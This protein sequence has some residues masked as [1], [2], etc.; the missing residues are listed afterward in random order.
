MSYTYLLEQGEEF[1]AASF[2]D[3]PQSVLSRLNLIAGK[4]CCKG[5]GTESCQSSQSGMMSPP[6]TE[7]L[8][9]G[10]LMSSAG[11]FLVKTSQSLE[12]GAGIEGERSGLWSEMARIIGEIRPKF[13]FMENSPMLAL[14]GLGRVLG[15]LSQLG[16]YARWGVLG[17]SHIGARHRRERLWIVG[18]SFGKDVEVSEVVEPFQAHGQFGR[19]ASYESRNVWASGW[20]ANEPNMV[21]T[22][23]DV[24]TWVD[25]SRSIGNSQVPGVAALA[26]QILGGGK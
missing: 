22:S 21:G 7:L 8:G 17:A 16:Y 24:S 26:F 1:S 5:S 25:R 13:A 4:S 23:H 10:K 15:D 19:V 12:G 20:Q 3:I 18:N 14:R 9:E 11:G 2:L 6:S